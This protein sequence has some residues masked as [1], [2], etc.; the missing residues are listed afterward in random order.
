MSQLL[1]GFLGVFE[2][3]LPSPVAVFL[4]QTAGLGE[5]GVRGGPRIR[6]FLNPRSPTRNPKSRA[7]CKWMS[8][9]KSGMGPR[10]AM[11][12]ASSRSLCALVS[13]ST[14]CFCWLSSLCFGLSVVAS[15]KKDA[16]AKDHQARVSRP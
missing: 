3:F 8:A 5:V 14:A 10:S 12:Q 1:G 11:S 16:L 4:D 9:R 2:F 6:R 7:R 15:A 13:Q